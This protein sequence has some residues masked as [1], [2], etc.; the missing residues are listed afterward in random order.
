VPFAFFRPLLDYLSLAEK[1]TQKLS[2]EICSEQDQS[3][4]M[5]KKFLS[6]IMISWSC[7]KTDSKIESRFLEYLVYLVYLVFLV[8]LVCLPVRDSLRIT[9][10]ILHTLKNI[11]IEH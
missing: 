2:Q 10:A 11:R 7:R 8:C 1:L 4:T 5:N 3:S 9:F 6:R